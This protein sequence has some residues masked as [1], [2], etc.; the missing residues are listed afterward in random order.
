[1]IVKKC[2]GC[3][4]IL[5]ND[6]I[7]KMGYV[8]DLSK[9]DEK[10]L[11]KRCFRM[12]HYSEL[13]KI[14]A[15]NKEYEAVIDASISKN[16]IF[17]YLIDLFDFSGTFIKA[18]TDKLRGKDV[19]IV[20]NKFDLFPHSTK[21]E[22]IVEWISKAC[23]KVFF[24]VIAIHLV[25][26]VKGYFLDDL[27][28]NIDTF[29]RGRDVYFLGCAN[30]GKSSLINALLKR[31]TSKTEDLIATSIIPGTT[32]DQIVVPFFNDNKAFIDT[33]GLINSDN[34]LNKLLPVSY[35]KILPKK[36][37]KPITYQ[38][39]NDN[40]VFFGGIGYIEILEGEISVICY[41]SELLPIH[42]CKR[43]R[44]KDLLANHLGG[45][46]NPPTKEELPVSYE[47]KDSTFSK[48]RKKDIAF[49]GL[50]F[51]S[52]IG[53]GKIRIGY[54]KN[55]K[56]EIRDSI[57]GSGFNQSKKTNK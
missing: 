44:M 30:V 25:S 29:R 2:F 46:L 51:A 26:A 37:I 57:I 17:V 55:T 19:I 20:A 7:D 13:P 6:D 3:G 40:A 5:Q 8:P 39:K 12:M 31:F 42:R 27:M 48:A 28:N 36:E 38:L 16:G 45:I 56:V 53:D 21:P 15:S 24:R 1:M 50:G 4:A 49:S 11:C 43:E 9:V 41:F 32:L 18:I 34:V 54:L 52:I 33:P 47:T 10:P 14:V 22:K 35:S 23:E